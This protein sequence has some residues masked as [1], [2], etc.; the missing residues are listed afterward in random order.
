MAELA[1]VVPT[2][3]RANKLAALIENIHATTETSHRIYFVVEEGDTE[4][5]DVLEGLCGHDVYA[6][7]LEGKGSCTIST[8]AGYRY[9]LEPFVFLA[10]DDVRFHS[11]WDTA[12]FA[13]MNENGAHLVGTNDGQGRYDCFVLLRRSY[14]EEH[15]GV[16][17][18]DNAVHHEY[19]HNYGDTELAEYAKHRGVWADAPDSLTEHVH[20]L[21]D[22]A[23]P[24]H[25]NYAKA[26]ATEQEDRDTFIARRRQWQ[27]A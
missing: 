14:I 21:F 18:R 4:T 9:S 23:D 25:P 16:F 22:K 24:D 1:I 27:A 19:H 13:V 5:L 8:N 3:Y 17:D 10:N 11:G 12:A 2:R 7:I 6:V 20:W 15:S 26:R